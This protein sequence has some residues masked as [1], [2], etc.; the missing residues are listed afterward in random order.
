MSSKLR[1][2]IACI[3]QRLHV[4]SDVWIMVGYVVFTTHT[5]MQGWANT[6]PAVY[7]IS[8]SVIVGINIFTSTYP[9][10][11][12][13]QHQSYMVLE[14]ETFFYAMTHFVIFYGQGI[15]SLGA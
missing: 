11:M 3:Q 5:V 14:Y 6:S 8:D 13:V 4:R 7:Y 15:T 12:Y 1:L 2:F 10:M 9:M